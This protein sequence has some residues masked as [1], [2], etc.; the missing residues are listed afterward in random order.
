MREYYFQQYNYVEICGLLKKE[1]DIEISVSTLKRI[2]KS[3]GLGRKNVVETDLDKI[4]VALIMEIDSSG[5]L[6]NGFRQ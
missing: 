1:H 6:K 2:V 3:L 5:M 4:A